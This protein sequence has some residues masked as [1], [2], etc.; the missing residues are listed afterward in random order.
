VDGLLKLNKEHFTVS[1][2]EDPITGFSIFVT[3]SKAIFE[4][5]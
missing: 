3:I 4:G 2:S 5:K 1:Q